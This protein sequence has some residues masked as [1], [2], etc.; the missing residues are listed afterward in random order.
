[1]LGS[2]QGGE[3]AQPGVPGQSQGSGHRERNLY[4]DLS[5]ALVTYARTLQH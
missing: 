4:S 5:E 1:M 2:L 3:C